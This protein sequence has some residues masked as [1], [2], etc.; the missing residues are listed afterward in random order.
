MAI[1]FMAIRIFYETIVTD[2]SN[3]NEVDR[4]NHDFALRRYQYEWEK[5]LNLMNFYDLYQDSPNGP[6]TK[7][8]ENWVADVDYWNNDRRYF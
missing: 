1:T 8:E 5:A 2:T 6:T 4:A 7:L 3:I